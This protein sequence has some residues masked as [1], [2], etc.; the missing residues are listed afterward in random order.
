[1][2]TYQTE[3]FEGFLRELVPLLPIHW[4]ELA[5]NQETVPLDPDFDK[6]IGMEK[7]GLLHVCTAREN[8][9]LIGYFITFVGPS[10]HYSSTT[11]GKVD[12]YYVHP[13]HRNNGTGFKLFK[14]HEAEMK[15]IGVQVVMNVCKP[16]LDH[17]ELFKSLGYSHFETVFQKLL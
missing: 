17:T 5:A 12:I 3:T 4:A 7:L 14:Y 8:G 11:F 2:V 6:Y 16:W 10:L 9:D 13:D 15:R 1:M